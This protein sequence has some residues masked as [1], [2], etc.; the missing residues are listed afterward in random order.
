MKKSVPKVFLIS[1]L[2]LI[3][4]SGVVYSAKYLAPLVFT[5]SNKPQ[6]KYSFENGRPNLVSTKS[7]TKNKDN[8]NIKWGAI[9]YYPYQS[10]RPEEIHLHED[11]L[12]WTW[13]EENN[14]LI[15][16]TLI[17]SC[18]VTLEYTIENNKLLSKVSF[19]NNTDKTIQNLRYVFDINFP[20]H[21]EVENDKIR[22]SKNKNAGEILIS[23]SYYLGKLEE[24]Y[25]GK[26]KSS[27]SYTVYMG[28]IIPNQSNYAIIE[29]VY[30]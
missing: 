19:K 25:K 22:T 8:L 7:D 3:N 20:A 29:L 16:E 14:K 21:F 1:F 28:D 24:Q 6:Y 5:L 27:A 18:N 12:E 13:R 2:F 11:N 17:E 30:Q 26:E 10:T 4:I 15:G 23:T 9:F